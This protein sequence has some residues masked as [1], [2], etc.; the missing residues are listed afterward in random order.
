MD[1]IHQATGL[2]F[3]WA[4][5]EF[6]VVF[7][8][9]Y[10]QVR[11]IALGAIP[12]IVLVILLHWYL[13]KVFFEPLAR[14][15]DERRKRTQGAVEQSEAILRTAEGKAGVYER[16]LMDA[17][18]SIYKDQEAV[19]RQMVEEQAKSV[20]A[21]RQRL[22]VDVA[23]EREAIAAEVAVARQSISGEVQRLA[24]QIARQVLSGSAA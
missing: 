6:F 19:R 8:K 21:S 11:P 16:A 10:E 20:E 4:M 1:P 24:D 2:Y 15:L 9:L 5:P 13:K 22:A 7:Y 17:R 18:S 12:T 23:K 14:V 3:A